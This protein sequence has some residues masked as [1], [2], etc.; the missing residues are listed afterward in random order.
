MT[1]LTDSDNRIR[2]YT[3]KMLSLL[4][5]C[6]LLSACAQVSGMNHV[7]PVSEA[8]ALAGQS[9]VADT[10][11][12]ADTEAPVSQSGSTRHFEHEVTILSPPETKQQIGYD[13]KTG[14]ILHTVR[15][16]DTVSK[17]ATKYQVLVDE[18]IEW[19]ALKDPDRLPAGSRLVIRTPG[20]APLADLKTD[21]A[22]EPNDIPNNAAYGWSYPASDEVE[23]LINSYGAYSRIPDAGR[24]LMLTFDCG[25]SYQDFARRIVDTLASKSVFA[26]FFITGDFLESEAQTVRRMQKEGHVIGNHTQ[27]HLIPP[28]VLAGETPEELTDDVVGLEVRYRDLTGTAIAPFLRPPEGS[29]SERSLKLYQ[30]LGYTTLFWDLTYHDWEVDQQLP[31][32]EALQL[33]KQQTRDGA[34]ILLH[35]ISETNVKILGDYIDW[36]LAEGYTFVLP[37]DIFTE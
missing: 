20:S 2:P 32:T 29:W 34:I 35:A 12:S 28:Q 24:Q 23:S 1:R 30:D 13:P 21:E 5:T 7:V 22:G 16:G 26:T 9:P 31:E 14:G 6:F 8:A 27:D 37:T 17:I 3:G 15:P 11:N 4:A 33:L 25:Y 10:E 18:I 36:A 19:N